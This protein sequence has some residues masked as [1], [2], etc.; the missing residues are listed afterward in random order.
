MVTSHRRFVNNSDIKEGEI[1]Y[2][3]GYHIAR[4]HHR[5]ASWGLKA[6][7]AEFQKGHQDGEREF[8]R[9][10]QESSGGNKSTKRAN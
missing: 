9:I 8:E 4:Y 1:N 6:F 2:N 3:L 10:V 5:I 7:S